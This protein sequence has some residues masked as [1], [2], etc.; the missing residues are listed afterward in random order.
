MAC[1]C[2][3]GKSEKA[4]S[5]CLGRCDLPKHR[6]LE[7][8]DVKPGPVPKNMGWLY[9]AKHSPEHQMR[10]APGPHLV[11]SASEDRATRMHEI[12]LPDLLP[13]CLLKTTVLSTLLPI[14]L[15]MLHASQMPLSLPF[16]TVLLQTCPEPT[17]NQNH[18]T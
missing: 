1:C 3:P 17:T 18:Q 2:K 4:S 11:L 7:K 9:T 6:C 8:E 5:S 16:H 13:L 10:L 15:E 12:E 14:L